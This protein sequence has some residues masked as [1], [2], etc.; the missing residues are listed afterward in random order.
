MHCHQCVAINNSARLAQAGPYLKTT[1]Q[2]NPDLPH[3]LETK[4][5]VQTNPTCSL[6]GE[7]RLSLLLLQNRRLQI[8]GQAKNTQVTSSPNVAAL[9]QYIATIDLLFA[10]GL[11]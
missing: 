10:Q 4:A 11:L 1:L 8:G 6:Q 3:A 2:I 5:I 7:L 9:Y